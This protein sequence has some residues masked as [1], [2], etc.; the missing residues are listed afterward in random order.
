MEEARHGTRTHNVRNI[1][2]VTAL[3]NAFAQK[4]FRERSFVECGQKVLF[5]WQVI[6]DEQRIHKRKML[7][8]FC[9]KMIQTW[10]S[11]NKV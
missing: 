8:Y 11:L 10:F 5:G 6:Y 1:C 3:K 2:S 7:L 9:M 4:N